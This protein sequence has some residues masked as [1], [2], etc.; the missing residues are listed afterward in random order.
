MNE[1]Y[2]DIRTDDELQEIF[3]SDFVSVEELRNKLIDFYYQINKEEDNY[4]SWMDQE[5]MEEL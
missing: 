4:D 1:V 2:I 3:T 5:L